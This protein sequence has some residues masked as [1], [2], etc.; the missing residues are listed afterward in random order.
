MKGK[1]VEFNENGYVPKPF[2]CRHH[3]CHCR[4]F[5][6]FRFKLVRLYELQEPCQD[7]RFVINGIVRNSRSINL[8]VRIFRNKKKQYPFCFLSRHKSALV[9]CSVGTIQQYW[10]TVICSLSL[11]RAKRREFSFYT[12]L[13]VFF[14]LFLLISNIESNSL[15]INKDEKVNTIYYLLFFVSNFIDYLANFI[16]FSTLQY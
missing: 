12:I 9:R 16:L 3:R 10:N 2:N 4:Y 14:F 5:T 1:E 11:T 13:T 6:T 7:T 8:F 15:G